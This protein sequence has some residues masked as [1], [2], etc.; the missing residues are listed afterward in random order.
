MIIKNQL[1]DFKKQLDG[2]VEIKI[3]DNIN[4]INDWKLSLRQ[5]GRGRHQT[6]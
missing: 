1:L 4:E 5:R 6:Q 2:K 3:I